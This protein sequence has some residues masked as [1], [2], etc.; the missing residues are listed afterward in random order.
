MLLSLE[1][2]SK[3]NVQKYK[4][5][6]Q[7]GSIGVEKEFGFPCHVELLPV[8]QSR[9]PLVVQGG[10]AITRSSTLLSRITSNL[11]RHII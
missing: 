7:K 6:D 3:E 10:A 1:V 11:Q 4:N 8:Q 5:G 2:L 9:A